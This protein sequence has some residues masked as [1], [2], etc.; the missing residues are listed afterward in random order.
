MSPMPNITTPN[1]GVMAFVLI[2]SNDAGTVRATAD[3]ASTISVICAATQDDM[4]YNFC[5]C[6][7]SSFARGCE[8]GVEGLRRAFLCSSMA[9]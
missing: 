7:H 4:L 1:M 6:I 9:W 8:G 2:H 3:T 5:I